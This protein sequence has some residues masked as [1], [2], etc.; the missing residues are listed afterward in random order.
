MEKKMFVGNLSYNVTSDQLKEAFSEV[1]TVESANV[2]MDRQ[3]QRSK[4][5]GFVE[6]ATEEEAKAALETM[7]G[8]EIDGRPL[9][10]SEARPMKP[11]D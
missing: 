10:V 1:G 7:E 11:R 8:R 6:M 3:T 2:I 5:F 9:K 4:G